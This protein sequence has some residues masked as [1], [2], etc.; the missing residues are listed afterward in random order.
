MCEYCGCQAVT[1][2][3]VLTAE[4]E[5]VVNLIGRADEAVASGDLDGA[6]RQALAISRLLVPHTVVE[7]EAL[8]PALARDFPEHVDRLVADHREIEAVL[9]RARCDDPGADW[10][11]SLGRALHRLRL[12]ILAEQDGAF[13]AALG[14]LD[15]VD[16]DAVDA[17]RLRV[18]RCDLPAVSEL[19]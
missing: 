4:H 1:A 15:P 10:P 2:I 11:A 17:V 5:A 9:G 8:F 18:G 19:R 3:A 16:W 7:E 13:P 12:H 14:A 6:R